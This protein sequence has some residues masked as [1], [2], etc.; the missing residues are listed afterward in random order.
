M[1]MNKSNIENV[2]SINPFRINKRGQ[3]FSLFMV[4]IALVMSGVVVGLY[5][6]Q[7]EDVSVSLIS[8]LVILEIRDDLDSFEIQERKLI[9]ESLDS[10]VSEFGTEEFVREFRERFFMGLHGEMESFLLDDLIWD[11]KSLELSSDNRDTFFRDVVYRE[12]VM[13]KDKM[14]FVRKQVGKSKVLDSGNWNVV[15]FPVDFEFNFEK[16]YLITKSG[17]EFVLEEV[18]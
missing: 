13:E 12:I 6:V 7:Q 16:E 18:E 3:L 9:F 10:V 5:F 17:N 2:S 14:R 4:V 11:G 1:R 15:H 8:P